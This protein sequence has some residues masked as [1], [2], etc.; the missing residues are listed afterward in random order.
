MKLLTPGKPYLRPTVKPRLVVG[1]LI[2]ILFCAK[3]I[4]S[5]STQ[6]VS[7]LVETVDTL[8]TALS[9]Q[10]F[11]IAPATNVA[12]D[13]GVK[14]CDHPGNCVFDIGHNT[15][16][17]TLF[18]LRD[19]SARVIAV[20]AN[21]ALV[22]A[23]RQK[24]ANEIKEGRLRLLNVALTGEGD[25]RKKTAKFWVNRR[26]TFSSF[27]E[28]SGCRD[29]HGK[30]VQPGD[31][32]FCRS[33]DVE[34]KT[35]KELIEEYGTPRYMKIDIEGMDA[36]CA[37]SVGELELNRRPKFMSVESMGEMTLNRYERLGYNAFKAV[38]QR[39]LS[40]EAE[41]EL[42][43]YSGPWGEEAGDESSGRGWV[44]AQEMRKRFPLPRR[45][46]IKGWELP[47][48]YDMHARKA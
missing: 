45:M 26:D 7:T 29:D 31:H 11:S 42:H 27:L 30:H 19:P 39:V 44:S 13:E 38:N 48:W 28:K 21:P 46:V 32:R 20:E 3:A 12:V 36:T 22:E 6:A 14:F 40:V 2:F 24:F 33:V 41:D 4:R 25:A 35:C 23:S 18:Y 8:S 5:S 1:L 37:N 17:D 43:G 15:G 47:T 34:T 10:T 16:Q 9:N